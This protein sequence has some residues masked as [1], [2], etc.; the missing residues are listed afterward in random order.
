MSAELDIYQP[1]PPPQG[2]GSEYITAELQSIA[3][4]KE[5]RMLKEHLIIQRDPS[6]YVVTV[7]NV[8]TPAW[9]RLTTPTQT[10]AH[11][12]PVAFWDSAAGKIMCGCDGEYRANIE[13]AAGEINGNHAELWY[14]SIG[15]QL[16]WAGGPPPVMIERVSKRNDCD[17]QI[18]RTFHF[19]AAAGDSIDCVGAA[20]APAWVGGAF[21]GNLYIEVERIY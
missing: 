2:R 3:D 18:T 21:P 13:W 19:S 6:S 7:Q 17:E 11:L 12:H 5:D 10:P 1:A 9:S 14:M 4:L 20:W 16:N 8:T 15:I